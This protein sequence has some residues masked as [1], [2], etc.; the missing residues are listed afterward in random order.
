MLC[1]DC[2]KGNKVGNAGVGENKIDSPLRLSDGLVK[3]V[4]V[5]QFGNVSLHPRNVGTDCHHGLVEFLLAAARDE[6]IGTFFDEKLCRSQPNPFGAACDESDLV[7]KLGGHLFLRRTAQ[8][9][10]QTALG[11]WMLMRPFG[12][13]RFPSCC[14]S[15][16]GPV[17]LDETL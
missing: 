7:F 5:G 9:A 12:R 14:D 6:D 10:D 15:S 4:K 1:D 11:N 16:A 17:S 3:T 2:P 13:I 8:C